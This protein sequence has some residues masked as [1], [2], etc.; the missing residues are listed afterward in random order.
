MTASNA[1]QHTASAA[2]DSA[3]HE[4]ASASAAPSE[5]RRFRHLLCLDDFERAARAYLP[6]PIFGYIAGAV[7]TNASLTD[8]RAA[9]AEW[10]FVPRMLV[11]VSRRSQQTT[12][13]GH[14]Y[15]APFGIA[16]MGISALYAYRGDLVLAGAAAAANIPMIMSGSSLIR[17]E[18]VVQASPA[19]WFQA[20]LPGDVPAITALVDRVAR[21]GFAT[22]VITVDSQVAGNRENNVRAGFST[23][24]RPTLRLAWDGVTRPRWL[25]GTFL[26]TLLQHGMP[27]F[28]N[29][30]ATRGAPI[31]SSQVIRDYSDRGNLAWSHFE[32]I[33]RQWKG[34]LVIKGLLDVDDARK[35][36]DTGADG[37]IVSNHGGR[38]LDGAVSPLRVLP[39]I[40][41]AC[42]DIPVMIDS[43]VRRGTDVLKSLAL[44]AR[45]VF[46]GRPF[47]YAAAI[48]GE[49]GVRHAIALLAGEIFR[50]M[51]MLGAVR[52]DELSPRW[53]LR[54]KDRAME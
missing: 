43:G 16:P 2:A 48:G 7:E 26:R 9:Y 40:V 14:T 1:T 20:Y 31:V 23:P 38:Q 4:R 17:L 22:L 13:F 15:A 12:L 41:A 10:G 52:L 19:T 37:I 21:A 18:D 8:N 27:H 35:A 47:A 25:C 36:R 45:F 44:G 11:D 30:F 5:E 32:L 42:P 33:R 46:V 29:N 24:L 34:R 49:A 6:R 3:A 28:E 39:Q 50:D 51:A 54:L 53:L